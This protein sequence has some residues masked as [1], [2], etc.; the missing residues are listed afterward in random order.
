MGYEEQHWWELE[1][2][3]SDATDI[4]R[5]GIVVLLGTGVSMVSYYLLRIILAQG[6]S[7]DSFGAVILM[8]SLVDIL[9]IGSLLG[10]N[11]GLIK[12]IPSTDQGSKEQDTYITISF[13]TALVVSVIIAGIGLY[14]I[15]SVR[16]VLFTE[17]TPTGF[18]ILT[19]L[20]VPFYSIIRLSAGALRGYQDSLLFSIVSK[21]FLPGGRL[22]SAAIGLL[23]FGTGVAVVTSILT[24]YALTAIFGVL[25]ILLKGWRPTFHSSAKVLPFFTFSIPLLFSSSL[26]ILLTKSDK[27]IIGYF[28]DSTVAVGQ[29]EIAVTIASLLIVFHKSFSFLLF[30]RISELVEDNKRAEIPQIYNHATKWILIFTVPLFC[31][32]VFSPNVFISL[33]GGD[34][35]LKPL[36]LPIVILACARLVDSVLGPNG[37]ALLGFGRSRTVLVY[38]GISVSLNILL[39]II[40][41]PLY[42]ITGAAV[43]SFVGYLCMNI[44]K[45]GDLFINHNF[46]LFSYSS[47]MYSIVALMFAALVSNIVPDPDWIVSEI[48]LAISIGAAAFIGGL[49]ALYLTGGITKQDRESVQEIFDTLSTIV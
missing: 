5:S 33:F 3:S 47:I 23:L 21:L 25:M 28:R 45:S 2:V 16:E 35:T 18:V 8:L 7:Q 39:N 44:L 10:L 26:Y 14:F 46:N 17:S 32:L 43:S 37:Q 9:I 24:A 6:L 4:G 1:T 48:A 31:I 15:D 38:N 22:V 13:L 29:Y 27:L 20:A 19:M 49:V 41:I 42:G 11:Q 36:Y 30:P 34:Y 12:Y 40:L